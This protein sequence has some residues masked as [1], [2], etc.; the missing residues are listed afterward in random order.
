M[1]LALSENYQDIVVER[2]SKSCV[3]ALNNPTKESFWSF[4]KLQ[5]N[6]ALEIQSFY[7]VYSFIRVRKET[8]G[9]AHALCKCYFDT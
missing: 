2:D 4:S 6:I 9:L 5:S 3:E 8:N 7:T 1:Q